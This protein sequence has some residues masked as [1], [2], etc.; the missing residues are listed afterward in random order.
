M[1]SCNFNAA[2]GLLFIETTFVA[3]QKVELFSLIT[4]V[5]VLVA[6]ILNAVEW[7]TVNKTGGTIAFFIFA[8]LGMYI[9]KMVQLPLRAC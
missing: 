6:I 4:V 5:E 8:G 7:A 3:D 1:V 9:Q 2:T